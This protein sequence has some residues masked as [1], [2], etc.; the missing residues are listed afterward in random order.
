MIRLALRVA[1]ADAEIALAE[2]LELVPEGVEEIDRGETI[3]YALYGAPGELPALPDLHAAAGSALVEISTSQV[4]D[5]WSERWRAF[6]RPVS[7]G[8]RL[9]V[10]PP[11][12]PPAPP[13]RMHDI[14]IDPGQAFGTGAHA[15]TRMCLELM[16]ECEPRGALV[17]LGCGTGVLCI[18][19]AKLGWGPVLGID[20]ETASVAATADNA[21]ANQV[22]VE[23]RR[24][25]LVRDGPAPAAPTVVANLV[26]PLLLAVARGGWA[27]PAPDVLIAGGLLREEADE[28]AVALKAHGL[29]E[30]ARRLEG[31]WATLLLRLG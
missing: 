25:D 30:R 15:T 22:D 29:L 8:E 7:V 13:S 17:D 3:E 11:W 6:H 2:L 1:R 14:V 26:R 5:D 21:A 31:E 4:A 18:A 12:A 24:W 19:A 27:G 20:H 23:V 10:R 28:V 9:Y 16:L